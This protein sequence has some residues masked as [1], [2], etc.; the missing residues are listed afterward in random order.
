MSTLKAVWDCMFGPRLIKI[1]GNGPVEKFYQPQS[2][3]KWGDQVI[4]SVRVLYCCSETFILIKLVVVCHLENRR[5][6]VT[7][8]SG[9]TVSK[10]LLCH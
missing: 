4:H 3:E 7:V 10:R 2:F 6:H 8:S 5:L 9:N 1:Y